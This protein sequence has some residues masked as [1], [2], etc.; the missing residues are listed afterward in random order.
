MKGLMNPVNS[1][2][3]FWNECKFWFRSNYNGSVQDN[4]IAYSNKPDGYFW[5]NEAGS[6]NVSDNAMGSVVFDAINATIVTRDDIS[7]LRKK[8][9]VEFEGHIWVVNSIS[10]RRIRQFYQVCDGMDLYEYT[11]GISR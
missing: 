11:L 6:Y 7:E 3:C 9:I 10:K 2:R 5:A 8:D 1:H 4:D